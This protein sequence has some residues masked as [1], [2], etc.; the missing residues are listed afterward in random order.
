MGTSLSQTTGGGVVGGVSQYVV[1]A[2]TWHTYSRCTHQNHVY[3]YIY[4]YTYTKGCMFDIE[5]L[6]P[7]INL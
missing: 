2:Q 6:R 3:I 5:I 4:I 1:C 7:H